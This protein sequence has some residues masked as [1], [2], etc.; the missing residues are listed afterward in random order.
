MPANIQPEATLAAYGDIRIAQETYQ[1]L[2]TVV[3]EI[4]GRSAGDA[5]CI[6]RVEDPT[7]HASASPMT[8]MTHMSPIA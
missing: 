6:V 8:P 1:P 2:D 4:T 3:V 7:M 5:S